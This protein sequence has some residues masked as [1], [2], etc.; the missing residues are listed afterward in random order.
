[1]IQIVWLAVKVKDLSIRVCSTKAVTSH[2][3]LPS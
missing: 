1:M 3:N 2:P